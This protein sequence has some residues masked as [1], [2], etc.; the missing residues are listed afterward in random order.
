[1]LNINEEEEERICK[2]SLNE[3]EVNSTFHLEIWSKLF[4][5]ISLKKFEPDFQVKC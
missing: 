5:D 2:I 1:M 3:F 4:Q